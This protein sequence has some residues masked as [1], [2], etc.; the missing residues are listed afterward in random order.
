M[1]LDL[2]IKK[3]IRGA[4]GEE[5]A[6]LG[7]INDNIVVLDADLS[8]ST[9]TSVFAKAHP[10]RF[11]N[12]GIAEQNLITTALGLSLTGK[13]PFA[14]SFAAF[15]TGR[16][17]DQI[18]NSVCYQNANVKI[19]GAHGGIT[20]GEDGASHQALE[21]VALMRNIPNMTVIVP[22]DYEQAKQVVDY[23]AKNNGPV[24]IRSSRID[25]PCVFDSN[26]KFNPEKAVVLKEGTDLTIITA[27]DIMSEVIQAV[28][29]L[30]ESG[31]NVE[32]INTPVI[33]PLDTKTIIKSVAKTKLAITIENH[34]IT[35]G[36]GSAV[37]E[38]LSE[39]FPAKLVRIGVNDTFGQS[40]KP[41]DLLKFY[42]L[43]AESI[44]KKVI[45][46]KNDTIKISNKKI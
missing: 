15:A 22:S 13:I 44:V 21:D 41:D 12:V 11:F 10:D 34:S 19:I 43:D 26:Y 42:G 9:K 45:E 1:Q 14:A 24:Y 36:I 3:S 16:T 29:I 46:I 20:V 25:V 8:G 23:A 17:Y 40:G 28:N 18:R 33:K 6:E 39:S 37:A 32:L 2:S 31:I 30:S 5:L 35:G 27:G 4:I 7:S 38:C